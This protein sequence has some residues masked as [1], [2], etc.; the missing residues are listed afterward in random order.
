MKAGHLATKRNGA[1][2]PLVAFMTTALIGFLALAIDLGMLTVTKV[3]AQN[4]ADLAAITAA[5][6]LSGNASAT[7]SSGNSDPYLQS[8]A[9]ANAQAAIAQNNI[10]GTALTAS[11]Q[12]G[13]PTG[14][15]WGGT[16]AYGSYDYTYNTSTN[17]GSF[18]ANFPALSNSPVSAV[19][20]MVRT[21]TSSTTGPGSFF[22]GIFGKTNMGVV[23]AYAQAVHRPRDVAMIMDLS[24]SMRFGSLTAF[25]FAYS[26]VFSMNPD[27]AQ[28]Q[29]MQ[30]SSTAGS[31]ASWSSPNPLTGTSS[32]TSTESS[33]GY[34]V[35]GQNMIVP[36]NNMTYANADYSNSFINSFYSN[37]AFATSLTRAF[38]SYTSGTTT[39]FG[40]TTTNGNWSAP[41]SGSGPQLPDIA[42]TSNA[43]QFAGNSTPATS[44]SAGVTNAPGGDVP[45]LAYSK[46]SFATTVN[47]VVPGGT[48]SASS[49]FSSWMPSGGTLSGV[50][51]SPSTFCP[52]WELDGYSAFSNGTIDTSNTINSKNVPLV[53][54][55]CDY[56]QKP[57]YG[58]TQGPGYYG[59][60]FF[61]WPPNPRSYIPVTSAGALNYDSTTGL[62][63]APVNGSLP[64][65]STAASTPTTSTNLSTFLQNL[66]M[67]QADANF[68]ASNNSSTSTF[69]ATGPWNTWSLTALMQW[70]APQ[71]TQS[72]PNSSGASVDYFTGANPASTITTSYTV[73]G[74]NGLAPT[75]FAV[76]RLYNRAYPAGGS[77]TTGLSSSTTVTLYSGSTTTTNGTATTYTPFSNGISYNPP[78]IA[79]WRLRFFGTSTHTSA[80][81]TGLF[82]SSTGSSYAWGTTTPKWSLNISSL[83]KGLSTSGYPVINYNA[84]IGW[85][86]NYGALSPA[87]G[88]GVGAQTW[89]NTSGGS[90]TWTSGAGNA[91]TAPP[92]PFPSQLRAGRIKYYGSIPTTIP[93]P[94]T[95]SNYPN[96]G[97]SGGSYSG[98]AGSYDA[99]FWKEVIDYTLGIQQSS[100]TSYAS[101]Q[102]FMGYGMDVTFGTTNCSAA[103][104]APQYMVYTD[105]PARGNLRYWFGPY[106]MVDYLSNYN[107]T[108]ATGIGGNS[109]D[110][111]G[112]TL[113]NYVFMDPGDGY[114]APS[115]S[116]KQGFLGAISTL[117]T[118][119]PNDW[120][121]LIYYSTPKSST[122]PWGTYNMVACPLGVNYNYAASAL[123]FPYST[124]SANGASNGNEVTPYD[125]WDNTNGQPSQNFMNTPRGNFGTTFAMGLMLAYN[126]FVSAPPTDSTLTTYVSSSSINFAYGG[127]GHSNTTAGYGMAGGLGRQGSQKMLIFET[128]GLKTDDASATLTSNSNYSPPYYYPIQY[129]VATG[130][131]NLPTVGASTS[132]TPITNLLSTMSSSSTGFGS[133]RNPFRCYCIGY[134]PVFA[135]GSSSGIA[136]TA[137]SNL[138]SMQTATGLSTFPLYTVAGTDSQMVTQM[139]TAF[140]EILQSG[141][142]VALVKCN[143]PSSGVSGD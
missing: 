14:P 124:I 133:T 99:R 69:S 80:S 46:T 8:T 57:F 16:P 25:D 138:Q 23:T 103:P 38:D 5:R 24:G 131:G 73:P 18:T 119:H 40:I 1:V 21:G 113:G 31:T 61:V 101:V 26:R 76:C 6:T 97:G 50:T 110:E 17:T 135:S 47:D 43:S 102:N 92:N 91:V 114:V 19:A 68:L 143:Y 137:T 96:F 35:S 27:P 9:T 129:N 77:S 20:V 2:V 87:A 112:N 3:Q 85:I 55:Q 44:Y 89:Y 95:A 111:Y 64:Y 120:F 53:W 45:L 123:F 56:S 125:N 140:K 15:T 121:T 71:K 118:N 116:C 82:T 134:G 28:P 70:M 115:Y 104:S 41:S 72:T 81:D 49:P 127:D 58:Y 83:T 106:L 65:D 67:K 122:N 88:G 117:Q 79:D 29:F 12:M 51:M 22:G 86:Q 98:G 108:D 126:Q 105:N 107:L 63:L 34:D 60:T 74:S 48:Y 59:K 11:T 42:S 94:T 100:S 128:D 130:S 141:I 54:T 90:L 109:N 37:A 139:K 84:I 78:F 10:L 66:G 75:F 32:L 142:Q 39:S 13:D 30:Y 7:N 136:S 36:A 33:L 4:A 132:M 52:L 93:S 62:P